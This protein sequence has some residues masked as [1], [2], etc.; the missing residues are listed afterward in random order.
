[1]Q[2]TINHAHKVRT[3][4]ISRILALDL[5]VSV[6]LHFVE[7]SSFQT[8]ESHSSPGSTGAAVSVIDST[9]CLGLS[10]LGVHATSNQKISRVKTRE[11]SAQILKKLWHERQLLKYLN[12]LI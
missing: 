8:L 5:V 11:T 1:M 2:T 10:M 3:F 12:L 6:A 7:Y 4:S 9:S